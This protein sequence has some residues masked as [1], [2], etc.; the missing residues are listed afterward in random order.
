MLKEVVEEARERKIIVN[1]TEALKNFILDKGYEPKYGARP[2]RRTIEKY[3]E[4]EITDA[5]L[6]KK[7]KEGS[8]VTVDVADD[9]VIL[10]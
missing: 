7:I 3:V 5:F 9:K 1:F 2:L 8:E 4:D 10:K 6:L